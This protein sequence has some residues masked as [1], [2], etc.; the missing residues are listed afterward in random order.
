MMS[1][2]VR[3][4]FSFPR[5]TGREAIQMYWTLLMSWIFGTGLTFLS[6]K[7]GTVLLGLFTLPY[8][9]LLGKEVASQRVGLLAFFLTGIGYWPNVIS[10]IG[11]RFPLYPLFVAPMLLYLIRGL[12][13]RH[14][15]DFI[16]SGIFLGLG[17]H[18]YSP[19]RIVPFLVIAA[20]VSL[21]SARQVQSPPAGCLAVAGHPRVDIAA[22]FPAAPALRHGESRISL[23]IAPLP[24]L[25]SIEQP[26]PAPWP[27]VF[28]SNTWNALR[29]V[30]L[31]RWR[32]SGSIPC[33]SVPHSILLPAPCS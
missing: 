19:F 10:R 31:E 5:N 17:L 15:N 7:I 3:P 22:H 13:T 16:L 14:R 21:Y 27:V 8:M 23:H 20:F 6:L 24:G 2:R 29:H 30:Q 25:G 1:A 11:L 33:L 18:G 28:L 26:L 9:Y 12:R 32:R 4:I